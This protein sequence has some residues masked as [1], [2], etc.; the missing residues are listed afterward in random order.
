MKIFKGTI[1]KKNGEKTAVVAVTRVLVHPVYRK[2]VKRTRKY[3]VH[4]EFGKSEVGQKVRFV[5]S[6]PYSKT[7]KWKIFESGDNKKN[8]VDDK[9][10]KPR[11]KVG[12]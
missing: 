4:D 8:I 12:K 6:K 9:G 3:H 11:K 10:S 7:K 1:L 5:A 2:R